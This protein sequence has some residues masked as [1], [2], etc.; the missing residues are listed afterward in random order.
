MKASIAVIMSLTEEG[1]SKF[2][3]FCFLFT[4]DEEYNFKGINKFLASTKIK[5]KLVVYCEPT[6]LKISNAHR[7]IIQ[8]EVTAYGRSAHAGKPSL[9]INAIEILFDAMK[10][11]SNEVMSKKFEDSTLGKSAFNLAYIKGGEENSYNHVPDKVIAVLDIRPTPKLT[12]YA[13]ETLIKE[14][15]RAK[16]K[17]ACQSKKLKFKTLYRAPKIRY[18]FVYGPLQTKKEYLRILNDAVRKFIPKVEYAVSFGITE[19]GILAEK[20]KVPACNFGPGPASV[21]HKPDEYVN[22]SDLEI[23][24]KVYEKLLI[25]FST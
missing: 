3:D 15:I 24:K 14:K 23:V 6:D 9:G 10:E 20:L 19:A 13:I 11:I 7:G 25:E 4:A 8:L 12:K 16:F 22:L 18:D 17:E 2:D 21:S 1:L 5:P